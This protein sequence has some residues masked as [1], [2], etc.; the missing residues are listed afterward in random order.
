MSNQK[1][2]KLSALK[3]EL[4]K[5]EAAIVAD[6][7]AVRALKKEASMREGLIRINVDAIESIEARIAG[8]K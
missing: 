2:E 4:A 6:S 7:R 8:I 3:K 1:P 5:C